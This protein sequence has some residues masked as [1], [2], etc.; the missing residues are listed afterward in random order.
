[1]TPCSLVHLSA[2][3][4]ERGALAIT[5][6]PC[7]I[8]FVEADGGLCAFDP[9]E[10]VLCELETLPE[11]RRWLLGNPPG[12]M[13]C[14]LDGSVRV[15]EGKAGLRVERVHEGRS[16]L[17]PST[18]V[19][20]LR[21][22]ALDP[23]GD[24]VVGLAMQGPEPWLGVFDAST[25][26][27][28]FRVPARA[29]A[30]SRCGRFIAAVVERDY[31]SATLR[32]LDGGRLI[33]EATRPCCPELLVF[34]AN[35]SALWGYDR[36]G[37]L[38]VFDLQR[39][40]L[41]PV[42]HDFRDILS[43][44]PQ[45]QGRG[46]WVET[47]RMRYGGVE[48]PGE[49]FHGFQVPVE[50]TPDAGHPRPVG[51]TIVR[52]PLSADGQTVLVDDAGLLVLDLVT[53]EAIKVRHAA[54]RALSAA[55]H[56][57]LLCAA[58]EGGFV[59]LDARS[60]AV[61][62]RVTCGAADVI[63]VTFSPD[64]EQIFALD[65]AG[66]LGVFGADGE[67]RWQ[68]LIMDL[69]PLECDFFTSSW[70]PCGRWFAVSFETNEGLFSF[71]IDVLCRT[72]RSLGGVAQIVRST[73]GSR[74]ITLDEIQGD[75][76]N[77]EVREFDLELATESRQV[78]QYQE[79]ASDVDDD[80]LQAY[81]ISSSGRFV[82]GRTCEWHRGFLID[83]Q[84]GEASMLPFH[85]SMMTRAQLVDDTW[86]SVEGALDGGLVLRFFD[87]A[88]RTP[89]GDEV[90]LSTVDNPSVLLVVPGAVF[91]GDERG[92]V[93]RFPLKPA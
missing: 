88:S 62:R 14:S 64:G 29:G 83:R 12:A 38:F 30:A 25:G 36:S 89:Q 44:V 23:W 16:F 15:F 4:P 39:S 53:M 70:S 85:V 54:V 91:I 45:A 2:S 13:A 5:S 72:V 55:P 87:L 76:G 59:L 43:L 66:V 32:V 35:P 20:Q 73:G 21:L 51:H 42:K 67:R 46:V 74:V 52:R 80:M 47:R 19:S 68:L 86:I 92:A 84:T 40:I 49:P 93:A 33:A 31:R 37:E 28:R 1:M 71:V 77:I 6:R 81:M 79:T 10:G 75:S 7:R 8:L 34:A 41:T 78:E 61:V 50:A 9:A 60:L 56:G 3:V 24:S 11:T 27:E 57:A 48:Q 17:L 18:S 58:Y 90:W 65:E 63:S 26:A 82:L 22:I 69:R